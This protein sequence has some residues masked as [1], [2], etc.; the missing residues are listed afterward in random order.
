MTVFT[1]EAQI[2]TE[3]IRV[4][5]KGA[6]LSSLLPNSFLHIRDAFRRYEFFNLTGTF[7]LMLQLFAFSSITTV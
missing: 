4:L 3:Y 5:T 7:D 6:N 2:R 1:S